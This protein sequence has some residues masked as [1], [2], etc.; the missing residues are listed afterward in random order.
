MRPD[1]ISS[2]ENHSIEQGKKQGYEEKN[3]ANKGLEMIIKPPFAKSGEE[4]LLIRNQDT[5]AIRI[6]VLLSLNLPL[7][8]PADKHGIIPVRLYIIIPWHKVLNEKITVDR[9]GELMAQL[10]LDEAP[11]VFAI[12]RENGR[13]C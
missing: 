1:N 5:K 2:C 11:S 4:R 9:F 13:C 12:R 3:L 7:E 10:S 6:Y 8:L